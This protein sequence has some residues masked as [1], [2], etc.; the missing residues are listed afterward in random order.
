MPLL[1]NKRGIIVLN[2]SAME[3]EF[4]VYILYSYSGK[5]T[6]VGYSQ[7]SIER[8]YW[9]NVRSKKGFTIRYRPWIMVHIEFYDN[10]K[11]AMQREQFLKSGV[12]RQWIKIHI[13]SN[14]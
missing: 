13:T 14:L 5:I 12:G 2:H 8:F 3:A 4:V 10:K 9:H 6:Y 7:G 11:E 1:F